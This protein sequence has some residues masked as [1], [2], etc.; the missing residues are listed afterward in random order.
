MSSATSV[1][2]TKHT[3]ERKTKDRKKS[4]KGETNSSK[5]RKEDKTKKK[6]KNKKECSNSGF[7]EWNVSGFGKSFDNLDVDPFEEDCF[8]VQDLSNN[9][10]DA[11]FTK[12][13]GSKKVEH[14]SLSMSDMGFDRVSNEVKEVPS[15]GLSQSMDLHRHETDQRSMQQH[16]PNSDDEE[17]VEDL[18]AAINKLID[19]SRQ[20]TKGQ[21]PE[22]I[23]WALNM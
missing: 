23:F 3:E 12:S 14:L 8:D 4:K 7:P 10:L 1:E 21:A 16:F 5:S 6:K 9:S 13:P 15:S 19:D 20:Q 17:S 22:P 11:G 2:D 18:E